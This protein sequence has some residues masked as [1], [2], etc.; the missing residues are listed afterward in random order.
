M[1]WY[2]VKK[3]VEEDIELFII[4]NIILFNSD[5]VIGKKLLGEASQVFVTIGED[6][7]SFLEKRILLDT[8]SWKTCV[9]K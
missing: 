2:K 7:L 4:L 9:E 8:V 5:K 6:E 3:N 1:S